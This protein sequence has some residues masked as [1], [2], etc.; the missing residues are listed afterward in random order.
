MIEPD[1]SIHLIRAEQ[2]LAKVY[3]LMCERHYKQAIET[4]HEVI[5][6]LLLFVAW[7]IKDKAK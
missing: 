7:L 1:Y 5:R 4:A 3:P 2:T 6:E